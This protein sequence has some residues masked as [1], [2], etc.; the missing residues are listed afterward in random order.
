M[1]MKWT[2]H[3]STF[4]C[5]LPLVACAFDARDPGDTAAGRDGTASS[6]LAAPP[7]LGDPILV[8]PTPI[9]PQ[10]PT[11]APRPRLPMNL[12]HGWTCLIGTEL[13]NPSGSCVDGNDVLD[14]FIPVPWC[15]DAE[16]SCRKRGGNFVLDLDDNK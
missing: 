10:A 11:L 13:V 12:M 8:Q 16:S 5:L 2:L 7:S 3:A 9:E 14:A 4:V 15:G 1:I 6:A